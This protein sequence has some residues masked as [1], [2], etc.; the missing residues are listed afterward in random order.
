MH[1]GEAA[2]G[3]AEGG[4]GTRGHL[5]RRLDRSSARAVEP[6][7]A[8]GCGREVTFLPCSGLTGDNLK[9]KSGRSGRGPGP[10]QPWY[11]AVQSAGQLASGHSS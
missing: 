3:M 2:E 10:G 1:V 9:E 8:P 4:A 7:A 11:S 6:P 5:G